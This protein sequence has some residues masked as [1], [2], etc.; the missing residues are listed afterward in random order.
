M[1]KERGQLQKAANYK[2]LIIWHSGKGKS[3]IERVKCSIVTKVSKKGGR[4]K[5]VKQRAFLGRWNC[6]CNI[7]ITAHDITHSSKSI[8][9]YNTQNNE[10]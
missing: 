9:L 8:K 5:A 7:V 3:N 10:P 6:L 2:I 4:D 1:L